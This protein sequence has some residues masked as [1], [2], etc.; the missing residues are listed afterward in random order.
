MRSRTAT[1]T[2]LEEKKQNKPKQKQNKANRGVGVQCEMCANVECVLT[3]VSVVLCDC[4]P[5]GGVLLICSLCGGEKLSAHTHTGST[6]R[7]NGKNRRAPTEQ[8]T[9]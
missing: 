5:L 1:D 8:G 7:E 3:Q 9:G 4:D 6:A 2:D